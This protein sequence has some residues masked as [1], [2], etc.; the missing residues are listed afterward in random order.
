[1]QRR[2]AV[3]FFSAASMAASSFSRPRK[4]ERNADR[5]V[6]EGELF[7]SGPLRLFSIFRR[8]GGLTLGDLFRDVRNL[9]RDLG[10]V[11]VAIAGR[12]PRKGFAVPRTQVLVAHDIE[13]DLR[14]WRQ[15]KRV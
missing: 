13:G 7:G 10:H 3:S 11:L 6:R 1:M 14:N 9:V 12:V 15:D 2:D 5:N 4:M 8:G